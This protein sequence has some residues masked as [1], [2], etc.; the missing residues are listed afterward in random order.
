M[1]TTSWYR[2]ILW[3]YKG[4]REY[5]KSGF[6][7]ARARFVEEDLEVDCSNRHY[8]ITGCNTGIGFEIAV[9][10]AK[11]GG[12][13]HMV[14]RNEASAKTARSEIITT[15]GNDKIYLH[16]VD[17]SRPREV[18]M[19]A[20]KFAA[21]QEQ[22]HVLVNN[23]SCLLNERRLDEDGCEI[24]VSFAVNTLSPYILTV[25]LLPVLQRSEDARVINVSSAGMLCVRLD[26]HD[27]MHTQFNPYDGL[28]FYFQSKRRQVA[29]TLWF[30]QRYDKVHFS[31]MHPGWVDTPTMKN[32][33]PQ[34]YETMKENLR[35][36]SE[37][38]DT[39][40][41]LAISKAAL[42]HPSGL[43][44]Q[45]RV[46]V[47]THL[48]LAWTKSSIEEENLL[49]ENIEALRLK[50]LGVNS[51]L[52][53]LPKQVAQAAPADTKK[54]SLIE[55]KTSVEEDLA[56]ELTKTAI[57]EK[58]VAEPEDVVRKTVLAAPAPSLEISSPKELGA[59]AV[60][61]ET[62]VE[63][64]LLDH[65]VEEGVILENDGLEKELDAAS[66]G[67]TMERA[68]LPEPLKVQQK[69]FDAGSAGSKVE[70]NVVV[71]ESSEV[72]QSV[73][74]ESLSASVKARVNEVET[75]GTPSSEADMEKLSS[76][77]I[78]K[79]QP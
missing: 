2:R 46:P 75:I 68:T 26:P 54:T 41:W 11:R 65:Q 30:A 20:A 52:V 72:Q 6:D 45:D 51:A 13:L 56:G 24:D 28:L 79:S 73:T 57:T 58:P 78:P 71:L 60:S 37:G 55:P 62:P 12:I 1:T 42:N 69:E 17:L 77:E 19:W 4:N 14:C 3:N 7:L 53:A 25:N 64:S 23:A 21:Q 74:I 70:E 66:A 76:I 36:P 44:F 29:M 48:P 22:I 16:C 59:S 31:S 18:T 38:A 35:S 61:H 50:V 63:K 47:P 27:L 43:F 39:A 40:V 9:A 32:S 5:A 49:M 33:L 34:I 10:V 8:I 15:T 67:P